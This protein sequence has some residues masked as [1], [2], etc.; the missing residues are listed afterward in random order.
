MKSL[1]RKEIL[2][3][4][5]HCLK[6]A[7]P[8]LTSI[9]ENELYFDKHLFYDYGLD[10]LGYQKLVLF[11]ED[12]FGVMIEEEDAKSGFFSSISGIADY[13]A[14]LQIYHSDSTKDNLT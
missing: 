13:L 10:S 8:E 11:L 9:P 3:R 12:E 2:S 4:I 7:K 14:E 1:P 6:K 5:S